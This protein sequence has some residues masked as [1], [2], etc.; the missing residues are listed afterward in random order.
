[1]RVEDFLGESELSGVTQ[2]SS[3]ESEVAKDLLVWW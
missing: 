1:M 2:E 3:N